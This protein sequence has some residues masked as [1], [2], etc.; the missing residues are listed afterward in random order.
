M[1][2]LSQLLSVFGQ[3]SWGE[4]PTADVRGLTSD[5]RGIGQGYVFVAVRGTKQDGHQYLEQ[6]VRLGAI[7]LV[8]ED[9]KLVPAHFKGALVEVKSAREALDKLASRFYAQPAKHLYCAGVTGTNGKTSTVYL[10]EHLLTQY[11]WPT[12]VMGTIDHHLGSHVWPSEL[13]TPD[14][15]TLQKRL[16]EFVNRGARAAAFEVSSHALDQH[17][18][19]GIPFNAGVF[20][21]LTRDHLDYHHD[22]QSYFLAKQRL[23][24]SLLRQSDKEHVVAIINADDPYGKKIQIADRVRVWSYSSHE[25]DFVFTPLEQNFSGSRFNLRSPQGSIEVQLSLP[26]LH[27]I[28][29]ATAALAVALHAGMSLEA[30][31]MALKT[32]NGVPGRLERVPL[33]E[34]FNVFVDYAHTDD[35][36]KTVLSSLVRLR[37]QSSIKARILTVFGCG[38]D[39][40]RGKRP[41]MGEVAARLSD[42][43]FLTSDNPRT[44][45][46]QQILDDVLEGIPS[47][48]KKHKVV[49]EVDRRKAIARALQSAEE[50]DV[51][52]IAGKGHEKYQIIG[53]ERHQFDDVQVVQELLK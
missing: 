40:D 27:N 21:N 16:A 19:D 4:D 34:K 36:L 44:E 18:A 12:G 23:F 14:P 26:G 37:E 30:A 20:T 31:A 50:N 1:I 49:I 9:R 39:R 24:S 29:N 6:A 48:T 42:Q 47:E 11:G 45:D 3:L 17:R 52:L 10:I 32:F 38:G 33:N 41:L 22:M 13:T 7:A 28:Y 8:V 5:S 53:H 25:G 46:P 35:A 15:V 51:I 2:K 43:V